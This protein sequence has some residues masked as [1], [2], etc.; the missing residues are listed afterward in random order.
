MGHRRMKS[1][2][3][4][5][6]EYY[7]ARQIESA[8]KFKGI[9]STILSDATS[10]R[11]FILNNSI[12]IRNC[13][14]VVL[15]D[16]ALAPGKDREIFSGVNTG[17]FLWTGLVLLEQISALQAGLLSNRNCRLYSA[18]E[19]PEMWRKVREIGG[20][21]GIS[22][23]K[24]DQTKEVGFYADLAHD[25]LKASDEKDGDKEDDMT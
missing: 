25:M 12:R 22:S 13:L 9:H 6:E 16:V 21:Y 24:K 11:S 8:L 3:I 5:D 15:I 19:S 1:V 7:F 17:M 4:V 14:S 23:F 18:Q 2:I 20:S 10:A